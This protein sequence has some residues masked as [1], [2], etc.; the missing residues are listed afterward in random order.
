[1]TFDADHKVTTF[2]SHWKSMKRHG[3]Q[4]Y[5]SALRLMTWIGATNYPMWSKNRFLECA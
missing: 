1:M 2:F 4:K 5:V 3:G